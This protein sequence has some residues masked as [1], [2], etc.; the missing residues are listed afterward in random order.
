M[1]VSWSSH[2]PVTSCNSSHIWWWLYNKYCC[3]GTEYQLII[4]QLTFYIILVISKVF[5]SNGY[6]SSWLPFLG[7]Y[8]TNFR[9]THLQENPDKGSDRSDRRPTRWCRKNQEVSTTPICFL[10]KDIVQRTTI[11]HHTMHNR[12]GYP[13]T[14]PLL[15]LAGIERVLQ[16]CVMA[17]TTKDLRRRKSTEKP[18][19][20][21]LNIS[22]FF[23]R[24][25][26]KKR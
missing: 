2:I 23:K 21:Q 3:G 24:D 6:F 10:A 13:N 22:S 18:D 14:P 1:S 16:F 4:K 12:R 5:S 20:N 8:S 15:L 26:S 7:R 11:P 25:T 9:D 19:V 17:A